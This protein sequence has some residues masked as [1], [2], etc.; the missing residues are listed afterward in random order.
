MRE[1]YLYG[2]AADDVGKIN[3]GDPLYIGKDGKVHKF[4]VKKGSWFHRLTSWIKKR[5][6]E[7]VNGKKRRQNS[8]DQKRT[9][10]E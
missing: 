8:Q 4:H 2:I 3:I 1:Q 5:Y 7:M 9:A 10:Q 6:F